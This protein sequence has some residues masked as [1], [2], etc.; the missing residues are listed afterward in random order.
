M[1]TLLVIVSSC[2]ASPSSTT[3]P[4]P[5]SAEEVELFCE[6]YSEVRDRSRQEVL[7]EL[8]EVAPAEIVGPI[9]R[10]S[11]LGGSFEDDEA[12]DAFIDRCGGP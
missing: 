11:E 7:V 5:A 9:K 8:L 10:A 4:P 2:D 6:R 1:A 12:I 3:A